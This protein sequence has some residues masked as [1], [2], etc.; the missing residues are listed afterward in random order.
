MFDARIDLKELGIVCIMQDENIVL[1][2]GENAIT[3][4]KDQTQL[5][6]DALLSVDW[7]IAR[8]RASVAIQRRQQASGMLT[9]LEP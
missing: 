4:P 9:K 3:F 7:I 1:Q 5:I 6:V 8:R 2:Q